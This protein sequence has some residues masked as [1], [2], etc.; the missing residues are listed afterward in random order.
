MLRDRRRAPAS[1]QPRR[2]PLPAVHRS[3]SI[4][5]GTRGTRRDTRRDRCR[6]C[7]HRGR[8]PRGRERWYRCD[9]APHPGREERPS[10]APWGA[11]WLG[12]HGR[13]AR[14]HVVHVC[15]RRGGT[16]GC[17]GVVPG[18]PRGGRRGHQS[19]VRGA[20]VV[21]RRVRQPPRPT[22]VQRPRHRRPNQAISRW[23][24]P[25]GCH[26]SLGRSRTSR[27][28]ARGVRHPDA[29]VPPARVVTEH[30]RDNLLRASRSQDG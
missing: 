11:R 21:H 7:R 3:G 6:I 14:S 20:R 22:T 13:G 28:G 26:R 23:A 25:C 18:T 1:I 29:K 19:H 27:R 4:H 5:V 8:N 12:R 24:H 10:V 9:D 2:S 16:R 17:A 15:H 30:G